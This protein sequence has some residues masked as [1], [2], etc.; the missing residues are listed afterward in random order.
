[1]SFP[2]YSSYKDSGYEW[3]GAIPTEWRI[4]KF[5]HTF[6]E[7]NEKID[8]EVVGPMLSVS[9]YRGIEVKEYDDE[10]RRRSDEDLI[11]YRIVRPGQLVVNTMWLNYA[12][13]G[14]S[15]H[16]G[17]VSPAYRAYRFVDENADRRF[18]HLLMRSS[19]YVLAYTQLLTGIRPNSLQMSRADLMDFPIVLPPQPV[20]HAIVAFLEYETAKIDAL[21][22]EQRRLMA[23][24]KEKRHA[25]ISR[26]VSKG[27]N[28]EAPL[29]NSFIEWLGEVP[30]HWEV[31]P[32][33]MLF[34]S[35]RGRVLSHGDIADNPG[36]YPVYSSQTE[37]DG[38]MGTIGTYD[39]DGDYLTW[40]TD[41]ANA[42]TVFRRSGR[43]NCTN[44]CGTLR[45]KGTLDLTF[46]QAVL[47]QATSC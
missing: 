38:E 4:Q 23:L 47:S 24:L 12:G 10:N 18:I 32:V 44:V 15:A 30:A 16:E 33:W 34:T 31:K 6:R 20:Q 28:A 9:G 27:L 41:G 45:A 7:S 1:V 21:I 29:K 46:M 43:F 17:H 14:V 13:L 2:A 19:A 5:R 39:F 22:Q 8:S 40:T 35:G 11:G 42:G 37:N 25:V 26:A 36:E 3:L